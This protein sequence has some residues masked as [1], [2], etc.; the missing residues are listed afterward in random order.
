MP[1]ITVLNPIILPQVVQ[2]YDAPESMIG[3]SIVQEDSDDQP[4]WE[5]DIEVDDRGKL[6]SYQAHNTEARLLDQ[7]PVG[8]MR[9]N[10]AYTRVKKSFTPSTLRLLRA[11][12][13][14]QASAQAG[15][16][17]VLKE[18]NDMR[19]KIMRQEE[20]SIWQM[21]Q[22]SWTFRVESGMTYTIDYKIP[23]DHKPVKTGNEKWGGTADIVAADI[24][25]MKRTIIQ[26]SGYPIAYA[27][28][29]PKTLAKVYELDELRMFLSDEQRREYTNSRSVS[30]WN[31]IDWRS[32][33]GGYTTKDVDGNN[34]YHYY[35]P[36]N[37]IIF[38]AE[39]PTYNPFIFRYGPSVDHAAPNGWTGVF[40]K[41]WEQEDPSTRFVLMEVSY[42]PIMLNPLRIGI[43]DVGDLTLAQVISNQSGS[44]LN[45]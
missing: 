34:I 39:S 15:E 33:N 10:F 36:D 29:N 25:L 16:D 20:Y 14:S 19:M 12:G 3:K 9:G 8:T 40:T 32:Y 13:N 42:M 5:Y 44:F 45:T 38:F 26:N 31:E 35:I 24:E 27:I 11:I 28:M 6:E 41:S 2:E 22:G 17:R 18:V 43:L 30:Q 23:M 1:E 37:K 7:L 21:F 4:F